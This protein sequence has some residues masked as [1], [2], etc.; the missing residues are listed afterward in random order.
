M[1]VG[2]SVPISVS[3]PM[4]PFSMTISGFRLWH[5]QK[6]HGGVDGTASG[7]KV[8]AMTMA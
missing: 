1:T 3:I 7:R 4:I 5:G 8:L 2:I 6:W